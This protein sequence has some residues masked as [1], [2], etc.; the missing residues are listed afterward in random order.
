[1]A[2]GELNLDETPERPKTP[3]TRAAVW[4]R[5]IIWSL[6]VVLVLNLGIRAWVGYTHGVRAQAEIS[7]L[8]AGFGN[9]E[10]ALVAAELAAARENIHIAKLA[11]V[12]DPLWWIVSKVP[13]L[14]GTPNAV[15]VSVAA[16][17]DVLRSTVALEQGLRD[18]RRDNIASL[19]ADFVTLAN[20]A[21]SDLAPAVIRADESL[22]ALDLRNVP[23]QI[24]TPLDQMRGQLHAVAPT[25]REYG[26]MIKLAPTMLG[27]DKPRSWLLLMQNGSEARSTGGLVGAVGVLTADRGKLRLT[28]LESNDRLADVT[29]KGWQNIVDDEGAVE[30]Y[31]E[32]LSSLL[33]L[34]VSGDFPTVGRLTAALKRQV[35]GAQVDGVMA[36]DEHTLSHLM[37]ATGPVNVDGNQ[38]SADTVVDFVTKD[39][40]ARYMKQTTTA[41]VRKKDAVLRSLISKVFARFESTATNPFS[42]MKSVGAAAADGR[43]SL[44]VR[45]PSLQSQ[46]LRSPLAHALTG[47]AR[48][49][50][51]VRVNNGG[52]NKLE[53]YIGAHVDYRRGTCVR[54]FAARKATISISFKNTAPR[55]GLVPYVSGRIDLGELRPRPQ[56]TNREVVFLHLPAGTEFESADFADEEQ[57]P[58][59]LGREANYRLMRFD[60][61]SAAGKT[62][63]LTVNVLEPVDGAAAKPTIEVQPMTVPMT[64]TVHP[65]PLCP[66]TP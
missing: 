55:A 52:G 9:Q 45:D 34:N 26:P 40:Y 59:G 30:V 65:A 61:E 62:Q 38:V 1:M 24:A 37:R 46:V 41:S 22:Q 7:S 48:P 17:D 64:A 60:V 13:V 15:R 21:V 31:W 28:Q 19:S 11:I 23:S 56:G 57:I 8:Q 39:V 5:R 2:G 16:I 29:I 32:Q 63:V 66:T 10:P 50:V 14:G 54:D 12:D 20:D 3:R 35:D 36:M 6:A 53:A 49:T 51:S 44:W 4:R 42:V 18:L 43:V 25:I 47:P 33:G 27:I 58:T